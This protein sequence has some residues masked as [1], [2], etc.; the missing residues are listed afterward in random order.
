MDLFREGRDPYNDMA[1]TIFGRTIDRHKDEDYM[2][3]FIGKTA[4]LG[5]GYQMGA[6]HFKL[7]IETNAK[8]QLGIDY[9]VPLEEAYR[10]VDIYRSKNWC[11]TKMWARAQEW[12]HMMV[13]GG[14]AFYYDYGDGMLRIVPKENKIYFPNGTTLYYPCLDF[15]EGSFTYVQKMGKRYV[16]RY[17]YGGKLVENIV[18]KH[19]RDIVVWQMLNIAKR[20]R[21]VLHT[22]DENVALVP[23]SES[24]EGTQWV[25]NEMKKVP[26]WAAGLPI[27]AEGGWAKEYS[28]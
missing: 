19:S 3:G 13:G 22:Y 28:K 4:V 9:S 17:M 12:L 15:E 14:P 26:T 5:L 24:D 1:S 8:V 25:I 10:I 23:E 21:V 20:Y 18:Q 16:N 11:I 6:P 27:D 7:T 2:E